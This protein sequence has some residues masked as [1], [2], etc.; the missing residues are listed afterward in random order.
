VCVY[1]CVC[2]DEEKRG[3]KT[4]EHIMR[5][6][7]STFIGTYNQVKNSERRTK[8]NIIIPAV[9][10]SVCQIIYENGLLTHTHTHRRAHTRSC[11]YYYYYYL[12]IYYTYYIVVII[13]FMVGAYM[14]F[15]F[16]PLAHPFGYS[17]STYRRRQ[18]S[19][20]IIL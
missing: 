7:T 5:E 3:E 1:V 17:L 4:G 9:L 11:T 18:P 2:G 12:L 10:C 6:H 19:Y 20:I 16:V 13:I 15:S 14:Y 8:D